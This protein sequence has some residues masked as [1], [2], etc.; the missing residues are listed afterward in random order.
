MEVKENGEI[1]MKNN[2]DN[3]KGGCVIS[4]TVHGGAR[5]YFM[6]TYS[7]KYMEKILRLY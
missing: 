4:P 6:E 2:V 5:N 3:I 7:Q 1:K